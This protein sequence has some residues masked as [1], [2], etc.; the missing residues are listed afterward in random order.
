MSLFEFDRMQQVV[1]SMDTVQLL[2]IF[3]SLL[4]PTWD[5]VAPKSG[6]TLGGNIIFQQDNDLKIY[7]CCYEK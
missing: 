2:T 3:E 5:Q 4:V 7:F 1:E 6:Y